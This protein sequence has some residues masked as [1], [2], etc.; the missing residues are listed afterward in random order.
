MFAFM[1]RAR[2]IF[3]ARL[4]LLLI[5][6][7]LLAIPA[8]VS[9]A[10]TEK[11]DSVLGERIAKGVVLQGRLWLRGTMIS[12]DDPTGGLISLGVADESRQVHFN[13][14]VVDIEKCGNELWVLRSV[15]VKKR[16]LVVSVWRKGA[17]EDVAEFE[18]PSKDEPIALL[19]SKGTPIVLSQRTIRIFS[20]DG[21]SVR[22]IEL[23]GELRSGVQ[24]STAIPNG[25]GSV[26]V[27]F[28]SGE[29]GGGLQR[30]DLKTG[31]VTNVERRDTKQLCEGPLN[32]D[33]DPVTGVIPDSRDGDCVLVSVG[34]VHM[35]TSEGRI[36]R[37]C[38]EDVATISEKSVTGGGD[39]RKMTE[40][41]YG[42][43]PT[44]EGGF[45]AITYRALYRFGADCKIEREYSLPALKSVSGVYLSR[46]LPGAIIVRTD[47]NWAVSTSGY[48]PLVVPSED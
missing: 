20:N 42:L 21:A 8:S 11:G 38:G 30:V 1:N 14:G 39:K 10:P 17:F 28:N 46:D 40:A 44:K 3:I 27:G 32:S 2:S 7:L 18:A 23:K 12:R 16:G 34:L 31:A 36:L 33:C 26:Y 41:F 22:L 13:R 37:V 15:S 45:W 4:P 43:V 6:P 25:S 24:V 47:V 19:N 48:T 35:F 5:V 29:W 9:S